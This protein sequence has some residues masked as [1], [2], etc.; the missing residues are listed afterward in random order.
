MSGELIIR[1][2]GL[3]P[4]EVTWQAMKTFTE[5]RTDATPDEIWI[6]EHPS[7]FTQG[8][9]GKKE[10]IL[11]P[12][13]IPI[14]QS[15]RGGQITYHGPGQCIAYLL[16]DLKRKS[17]TVREFVCRIEQALISTLGHYGII[18]TGRRDAPGVYVGDA[19][20]AS[21]GLRVRRG[22]SYHG[23]ALNVAMDLSP[24]AR[25]HPCGFQNL[26]MIQMRDFV[27]EIRVATVSPIF[28]T[29]F[30]IKMAYTQLLTESG[31]WAP[32]V[33]ARSSC[34]A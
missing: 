20:I 26:Q 34:D 21:L 8:Q 15:D 10:H 23:L 22:R 31:M 14:V 3:S 18:G 24:F 13:D 7:I 30:A 19:K 33:D 16:V 29:H 4:Y 9:T 1:E 32:P 5:H 12:G 6:L 25:I 27:N 28:I 17:L 2:L 11:N